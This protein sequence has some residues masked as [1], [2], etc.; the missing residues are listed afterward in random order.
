MNNSTFHTPFNKDVTAS[1]HETRTTLGNGEAQHDILD[2]PNCK[3][4]KRKSV[5]PSSTLDKFL[6][7]Q[8]IH[9]DDETKRDSN[10]TSDVEFMHTSIIN[11]HNKGLDDRVE[12]EEEIDI[13]CST[14]GM[15]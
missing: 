6:K 4:V 13:D 8:G 14:K 12:Q 11:E 3:H 1:A 10:I 7:D 15:F 2:L 9:K 5:I